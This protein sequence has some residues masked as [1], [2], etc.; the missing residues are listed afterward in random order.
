MIDRSDVI[1]CDEDVFNS[2][3][4]IYTFLVETDIY[5][6]SVN[7]GFCV[8]LD[9]EDNQ[10]QGDNKQDVESV[11]IDYNDSFLFV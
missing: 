8:L 6:V 5:K 1:F 4:M 7:G 9:A 2:D 11:L 10:Y 3:C